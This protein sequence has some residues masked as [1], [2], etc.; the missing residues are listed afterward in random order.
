[1]TRKFKALGLALMAV[2]AMSAIG[3]QAAPAADF[4]FAANTTILT[5]QGEN[6]EFKVTNGP[7]TCYTA[8]FTAHVNSNTE[9]AITV[10]PVYTDC[11]AFGFIG[12]KITGFGHYGEKETCDYVLKADG[13][14]DLECKPN[15]DVTVHAGPCVAHIPEQTGLGTVTY[16]NVANGDVEVGINITDITASH[17]DGLFCT[18]FSGSG[19]GKFGSLTGTSVVSGEKVDGTPVNIAHNAT[20]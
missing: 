2:F 4:E 17:T 16:K 10:T 9:T 3:T 15:A 7:T 20:G 1:M 8:N 18:S 14:V 5:A 19:E 12:T 6:H 13:T 11:T